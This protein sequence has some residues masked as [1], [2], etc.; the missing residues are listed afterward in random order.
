MRECPHDIDHDKEKELWLAYWNASKTGD[1]PSIRATRDDLV[2]YHSTRNGCLVSKVA[3]YVIRRRGLNRDCFDDLVM[4][5]IYYPGDKQEGLVYAIEHYDPDRNIPFQYYAWD[6][7][8]YAMV[9]GNTARD[10]QKPYALS[11]AKD[12]QRIINAFN[13]TYERK[14]RLFELSQF[15][16]ISMEQ[17]KRMFHISQWINPD[18]IE[19]LSRGKGSDDKE[20]EIRDTAA[21]DPEGNAVLADERELIVLAQLL[22]KAFENPEVIKGLETN[23]KKWREWI[24]KVEKALKKLKDGEQKAVLLAFKYGM[25]HKEVAK[26]LGVSEQNSRVILHRAV[27]KLF[28]ILSGDQDGK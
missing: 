20:Q 26:N 17:L 18:S 24:Q 13:F 4:D 21:P 1:L 2:I 22:L 12:L 16:G 23:D 3:W 7:I 19:E 25:N 11:L 15:S 14:P 9:H 8:Q 6:L 27:H 10:F 28:I 5:G